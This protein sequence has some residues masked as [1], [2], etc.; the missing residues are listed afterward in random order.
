MKWSHRALEAIAAAPEAGGAER[1]GTLEAARELA[2]E[3]EEALARAVGLDEV[4]DILSAS[5][6]LLHGGAVRGEL[7]LADREPLGAWR[8]GDAAGAGP[9][10]AL[11]VGGA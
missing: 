6:I 11:G 3:L 9:V 4:E 8:G 7:L 5:A 2:R 1:A 10:R